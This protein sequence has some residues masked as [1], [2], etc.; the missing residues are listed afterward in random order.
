MEGTWRSISRRSP[1]RLQDR[2]GAA[3]A[4]CGHARLTHH[5]TDHP[6]PAD[7]LCLGPGE[8]RQLLAGSPWRRFVAVGDS[9][10]AGT[11]DP[12]DGFRDISWADRLA[13]WLDAA[14]G[15]VAYANLGVP[16]LRAAEVRATQLGPA[17][18]FR[19]DLAV[20]VAGGNDA[21][22]RS[23]DPVAV[24]RQLE[25]IV[26]PLAAAG[27]TVVTFGLFDL[28]RTQFVPVPMRAGLRERL[29][30][31]NR[32][33]RGLTEQVGGVHVDFVDHVALDESLLS[34]DMVHANRRGHAVIAAD[35]ARALAAHVA[36]RPRT[37][38]RLAP[39][40]SSPGASRPFGP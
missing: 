31:L 6:E 17:L 8:A 34:A 25:A 11:G 35:V 16:T 2:A 27:A 5:R 36:A 13:E 7:R 40:G 29:S 22:R 23:F 20:V 14:V 24:E 32:V 37:V 39:E 30:T 9:V 21:L 12:V 4:R 33:V 18:A 10:V 38:S 28:S 3:T 15:P 1:R 26:A 19:P